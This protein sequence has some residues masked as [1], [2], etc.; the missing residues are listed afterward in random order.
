MRLI[1]N[2]NPKTQ[3]EVYPLAEGWPD[4]LEKPPLVAQV[5]AIDDDADVPPGWAVLENSAGRGEAP[6]STQPEGEA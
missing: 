5:Y 6:A 4:K 2:A 1:Y 3:A